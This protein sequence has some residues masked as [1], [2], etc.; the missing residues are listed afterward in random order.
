[1]RESWRSMFTRW[2]FNIFPAF[3][4]TGGRVTFISSDWMEVHLKIPLNWRT[5]NYVGTIYGGSIYGAVDPMYMLMLIKVLGSEYVV[6]DKSA[7]VK[8]IRPGRQTLYARFKLGW[9]EIEYI[10]HMLEEEGSI[11]RIYPVELTNADG[12]VHARITKTIYISKRS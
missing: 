3:R 9:G 6:W 5:R 4:G 2:Y 12:Q 1:M 8:F 7:T 11:D 10:K